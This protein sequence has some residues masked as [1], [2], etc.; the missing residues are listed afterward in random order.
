MAGGH[1]RDHLRARRPSLRT[2]DADSGGGPARL[3]S[4]VA[5][6][7]GVWARV[8]AEE[9]L[10]LPMVASAYYALRAERRVAG[11]HLLLLVPPLAVA[12]GYGIVTAMRAARST[13]GRG[14]A[15]AFLV[16]CS[17]LALRDG[18][19]AWE[20]YGPGI[21]YWGGSMS[22]PLYLREAQRSYGA[23]YEEEA[24]RRN[25]ERTQPAERILVWAWQ[26][27]LYALADGALSPA[28]RSTESYSPT[29]RYPRRFLG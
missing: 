20:A 9:V 21:A 18:A 7:R 25:C 10:A 22:R 24:A 12:G 17:V 14:M 29:R 4:V 8:Q 27:G 16:T 13:R 2:G 6:V 1:V 5:G 15:L 26:P 28:T 3:G 23:V 11:Y 19:R